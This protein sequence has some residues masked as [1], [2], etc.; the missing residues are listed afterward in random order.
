MYISNDRTKVRKSLNKF[1][2]RDLVLADVSREV[3]V[4]EEDVAD[5]P[6]CRATDV[7]RRDTGDA[8][9]RRVYRPDRPMP[10]RT[11]RPR[12]RGT[13]LFFADPAAF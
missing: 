7:A 1:G 2:K 13:C 5:E 8:V 12:Y 4:L 11:V 3:G 6:L 9:A 10:S